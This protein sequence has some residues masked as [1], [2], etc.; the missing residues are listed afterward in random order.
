MVAVFCQKVLCST[1]RPTRN[2]YYYGDFRD[3]WDRDSSTNNVIYRKIVVFYTIE[4]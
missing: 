1:K 4:K 2:V 3:F